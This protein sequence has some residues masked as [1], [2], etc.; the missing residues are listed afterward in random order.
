VAFKQKLA[1][2]KLIT[3]DVVQQNFDFLNGKKQPETPGEEE[4]SKEPIIEKK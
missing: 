4:E 2:I 1:N 3:Q